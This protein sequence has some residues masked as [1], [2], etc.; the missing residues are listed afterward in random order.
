MDP[1]SIAATVTLTMV[2]AVGFGLGFLAGYAR[3]RAHAEDVDRA[4]SA[5]DHDGDGRPGG[6]LPKSKRRPF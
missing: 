4:L 5:F 6:S 1:A 2:F 3:L